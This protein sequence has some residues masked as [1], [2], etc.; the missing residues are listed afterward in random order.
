MSMFSMNGPW[1]DLAK[2]LADAPATVHGGSCNVVHLEFEAPPP[3]GG[4][5]FPRLSMFEELKG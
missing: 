2:I 4:T 5:K 1:I 3:A